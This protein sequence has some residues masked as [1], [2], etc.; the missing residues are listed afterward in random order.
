MRILLLTQWFDPEPTFKGLTFA[1]ELTR[2]G[3][4]VQVLTG[5]PNYPGGKLYP[6][7]RLRLRQ[8]ET[9]DG[10]AVV[11]VPLFPSHSRSAMGRTLN[12]V[13]FAVAAAVIGSVLV[14]RPQIIYAYHPPATI[15]IPAI[16]LRTLFGAQLVYDIQD[17]W[18]DTLA[19]TGMMPSRI[20]S[21]LV[22]VLCQLVYRVSDH[23]VVLSRGFAEALVNR[24]VSR[25]KITVIHNWCDE[26][27]ITATAE[28][29][30]YDLS[31]WRDKF[32]V[33]FAGTIGPAQCLRSVLDA[34]ALVADRCARAHFLFVGEGTD[35]G[36]LRSKAAELNLSNV[37][38]LPRVPIDKV[39]PI[40]LRADALLVHLKNDPLFEIT[41]PSKTQAYMAAGRPIIMAVPGDAAALVRD[42]NCGITCQPEN[43]AGLA[44]AVCQLAEM[45][46][47]LRAALGMNGR[48]F[49][50]SHLSL[51][52]GVA[53]FDAIFRREASLAV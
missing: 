1:R 16:V 38:F 51:T 39:A 48:K 11:R 10:I 17:L 45:D 30:P 53:A 21:W 20:V 49:Y 2:L 3:H 31:P 19:A 36:C 9:I 42:A 8:R 37:T 44:E 43:S 32:L 14:R 34:A 33:V 46:P 7:Y 13:T 23:I 27:H 22:A 4:E 12:Y 26:R 5:F 15:G 18:P 52:A 25:Q 35:V 40:L 50:E 24:G 6:G 28:T 29:A 47:P 41:I